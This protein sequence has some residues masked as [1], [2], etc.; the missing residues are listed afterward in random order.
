MHNYEN[1]LS[2][3]RVGAKIYKNRVASAP[4]GGVWDEEP[5]NDHTDPEQI[6]DAV[7]KC[8]GGVAVYEV[9]ETAVSPSGGRGANE[10]YGFEDYS[11]GH[12]LRYTEYAD[13]IHSNGPG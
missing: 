2:P 8:R 13:A 12:M 1:L 4:R 10:F 11:E 5:G 9:G 7:A 3:I 6:A